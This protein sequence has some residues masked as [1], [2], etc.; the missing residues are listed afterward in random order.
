LALP[1]ENRTV[2]GVGSPRMCDARVS[3]PA[4]AVAVKVPLSTMPF[5]CVTRLPG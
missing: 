5:A 3:S 1:F 2:T 4:R